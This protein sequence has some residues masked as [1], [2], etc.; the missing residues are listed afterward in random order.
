MI[1]L[2]GPINVCPEIW[3][4]LQYTYLGI[5]L[6]KSVTISKSIFDCRTK[7]WE[8]SVRYLVAGLVDDSSSQTKST[9]LPSTIRD[10]TVLFSEQTSRYIT[11]HVPFD[12]TINSRCLPRLGIK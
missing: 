7:Y 11:C 8:I 12:S 1:F 9:V 10:G 2:H 4:G 6:T 5:S 3:F